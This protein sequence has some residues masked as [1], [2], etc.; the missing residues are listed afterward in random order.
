MSTR[1]DKRHRVKAARSR[2]VPRQRAGSAVYKPATADQDPA[3]LTPAS[4][5]YHREK[6]RRANRSRP[7]D[8]PM[9]QARRAYQAQLAADA[10]KMKGGRPKKIVSHKPVRAAH[11]LDEDGEI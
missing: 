9:E 7:H 10:A 8:H 2:R 3:D 5:H 6:A 4:A 11:S 1:D